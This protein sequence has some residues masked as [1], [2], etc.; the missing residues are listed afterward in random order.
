MKI[1][2][3]FVLIA[4]VAFECANAALTCAEANKCCPGR[5]SS[6]LVASTTGD[7]CYCDEGCLETGD[8]CDDYK[9]TCEAKGEYETEYEW[10]DGK[11]HIDDFERIS[12]G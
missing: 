11:K 12:V 2:L 5:D 4:A 1:C 7:Y 6:C 8:C 9:T 10:D 3:A